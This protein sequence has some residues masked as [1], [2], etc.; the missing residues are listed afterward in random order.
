M[1][2]SLL[3]YLMLL[4]AF[5]TTQSFAQ[6]KIVESF[7]YATGDIDG[8]GDA[9]DGWKG[10]WTKN[11]GV[12]EVADGSLG[13]DLIG[14]SV[15]T[16]TGSSQVT[17]FRELNEKW[18]D[19]GSDIWISFYIQRNNP[20]ANA[21]GGLSLFNGN[22]EKLFMG[23][24][25]Q[26]IFLGFDGKTTLTENGG[27]NHI[28]VKLEMDGT[29]A[30]DSAFMWVNYTGSTAPD[31]T[32]AMQRT[33]W[34]T[35]GFTKV[36]IAN[37]QSYSISYDN[38]CFASEFQKAPATKFMVKK[39]SSALTIDGMGDDAAWTGIPK[40]AIDKPYAGETPVGASATF[41][42]LYDDENIYVLV[43]VKDDKITV[44][45][46]A[47]WKGDK[48][49]IYFGL[50]GYVP[51]VGAS[52][53]HARQ[54]FGVASQDWADGTKVAHWDGYSLEDWPGVKSRETDGVSI[55]YNETI[56]GY[57]YEFKINKSA[58]EDV[59]FATVDSLGFDFTIA[60]NDIEGAGKGVRNRLVYYNSGD[61]Q[62]KNENWGA[63]D[64]ASMGFVK[65]A[66]EPTPLKPTV[67]V[68]NATS[69]ISIDGLATD[70]AWT[71][72]TKTA[73]AKPYAGETVVGGSATFQMLHDADNL[74]VFV[75]VKDDKVTLDTDA[76][77]K[78]DKVEI[79][80]G[81]PGYV[82][83]KGAGDDHARQFYG[84]ASQEWADNPANLT[85]PNW[86]NTE[87]WP[88]VKSSD[89]DGVTF[90]Y[91]E[92]VDGYNYEFQINKSALENVDF[93]AIDSLGFDI[94]LA[95]NDVEGAGK[96]VRNR[97]VYYNSG[98]LQY[99]S[100]NWG[101][102][103]LANLKF[104][105]I[106][107]ATSLFM[108]KKTS[109]ELVIDGMADET[110]WKAVTKTAIAK[111]YAGET[112]EG[113]SA[114]FQMLYDTENLYV[115]V[116]V[117]DDF[118]TLDTDA[119]WKGDKIEIYFGLPGYVPGKG[120]SDDHAR[121][122]IGNA[123]QD[124]FD[125]PANLSHPNWYNTE[126]WPGVKSRDTDGVTFAYNETVDGYAYEFKFNISALENVDFATVDSLAFD[127]T[128]ADNDVDGAGK[129]VRNR[130]VY[131]NSGDLQYA[132]ENW[133]AMDLVGLGFDKTNSVGITKTSTQF[134][135]IAQNVL[136]FKGYSS[137][138]DVEVYS[139]LGQKVR[140]AKNINE[141]DVSSL[142]NGIYM[143]R[144]NG[145]KQAFKVIK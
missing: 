96:G 137:A 79:Y 127:F 113:A 88:G 42:M 105:K 72:A 104:E 101:A 85:H 28:T 123:S 7:D 99:A 98:D 89:T 11:G 18:M 10:A 12:M 40:T 100:E 17:Y 86:Y 16:K 111:P 74:Y 107:P 20:V 128:L 93:N 48:V 56:D 3:F 125:N 54:F 108:V 53:S 95:D 25:W 47:D 58:L 84:N 126:Y 142:R 9:T 70:M 71:S 6:K 61:L 110:E 145:G 15:M 129:G 92:T 119:D 23:C 116:D 62:Y 136:R 45:T 26:S 134:A 50:P 138:V 133:S 29:V 94:T 102:M 66:I 109:S 64:L 35:D 91:N 81:L 24:P 103:D 2:N 65:E 78:G 97:L 8:I 143:V 21:W 59:D 112:V 41:Q 37:D 114:T 46:D 51:G 77:W 49:E 33:G 75:N 67:L 90:A 60:D 117:K 144:V 73:V 30:A 13:G 34:G 38:I 140:S 68:K 131:Y 122:F 39:A 130:L 69:A 4:G 121:Q 19:D 5:V 87:F 80:F 32:T 1:R 132:S 14:N 63:M 83:G 141:L 139:I 55:G 27:L 120:A 31:K 135:Y 57:T 118:V 36:R 124:W 44:D 106:T 52:G 82:P 115:F 22:D 43:D 76:D